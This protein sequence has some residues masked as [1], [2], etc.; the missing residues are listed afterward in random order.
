[1]KSQYLFSRTSL[2]TKTT[3]ALCTFCLITLISTSSITL[4]RVARG[5]E[6]HTVVDQIP[7]IIGGMAALAEKI[8][9]PQEAYDAGIEGK[10]FVSVVVD[11]EGNITETK[12]VRS[13][14]EELNDA[15][16]SAFDNLKFEPGIHE[17]E[18]VSVK[19]TIP[20]TFKLPEKGAESTTD[21]DVYSIVDVVPEQKGG[22]RS[23]WRKVRLSPGIT[24]VG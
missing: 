21:S 11:P 9:Y 3:S 10:V 6:V 18:K 23:L 24:E 1:M 17:G 5:Q 12:V 13:D 15:A 2:F 7:E 19:I 14:A 20:I 8:K 4:T 22:L 16:V